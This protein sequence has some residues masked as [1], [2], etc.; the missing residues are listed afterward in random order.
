LVNP[1]RRSLNFQRDGSH[2]ALNPVFALKGILPPPPLLAPL[3]VGY[4]RELLVNNEKFLT[5][6]AVGLSNGV[7]CPYPPF[8]TGPLDLERLTIR[9]CEDIKD[10]MIT[11][12]QAPIIK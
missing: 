6:Q 8:I 4:Q 1:V 12:S 11:K 3:E 7:K 5:G 9:Y 10:I 2:R